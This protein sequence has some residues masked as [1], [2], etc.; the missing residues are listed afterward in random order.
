MRPL[1]TILSHM[2]EW[3]KGILNKRSKSK[4]YKWDIIH[5]W[6]GFYGYVLCLHLADVELVKNQAFVCFD[7]AEAVQCVELFCFSPLFLFISFS[8]FLPSFVTFLW[9][10][11]GTQNCVN[12]DDFSPFVWGTS[13]IIGI[14]GE[15]DETP[16]YWR[17]FPL[18]LVVFTTTVIS[19][20]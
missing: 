2:S 12:D 18:C 11:A 9:N 7:Y 6:R 16:V 13:T 10:F 19:S 20:L 17:F 1:F 3:W 5:K 8:F 14:A 15:H 4:W